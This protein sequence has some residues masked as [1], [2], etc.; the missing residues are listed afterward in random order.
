MGG[1]YPTLGEKRGN[2]SDDD[3]MRCIGM[4]LGIL[5]GAW[6]VNGG[7]RMYMYIYKET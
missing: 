6:S 5:D 7:K 2:D 4:S 3:G 1:R